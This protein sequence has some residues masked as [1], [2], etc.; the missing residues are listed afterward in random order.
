MPSTVL[1]CSMYFPRRGVSGP[2]PALPLSLLPARPIVEPSSCIKYLLYCYCIVLYCIFVIIQY[3]LCCIVLLYCSCYRQKVCV[4]PPYCAP[5]PLPAP[6]IH[7]PLCLFLPSQHSGRGKSRVRSR[8]AACLS[9]SSASTTPPHS[10]ARTSCAWPWS[11][12]S[13]SSPSTTV[14][15]THQRIWRCASVS[16]LEASAVDR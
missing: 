13:S 1:V 2:V 5:L 14:A 7:D 15:R 6:S 16:H 8:S 9:P 11:R 3:V 10:G 4:F 12:A